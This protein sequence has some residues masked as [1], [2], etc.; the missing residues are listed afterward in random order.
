MSDKGTALERYLADLIRIEGAISVHRFMAEVLMHPEHGYYRHRDPLGAAGDFI[1]APE[2]SQMFGELLGLWLADRWEA[3]GRPD[4]VRLVELGPGR[5]TLMA[6]ALRA[7]RVV[8][9]LLDAADVHMVEASTALRKK[10]ADVVN[11]AWHDR[12]ETVPEGPILV[13]ANEF[14]DALPVH[15]F[16]RGEVGWGERRV[17]LDEAGKL[18]FGIG[19]ASP[20]LAL[21]PP[22]LRDA[23][24]G[25]IVEICPSALSVMGEIARRMRAHGGAGLIID[26]GYGEDAA[27][28]SLQAVRKHQRVGVLD[29]PGD[30]DL[31]A[32]VNFASLMRV[33]A[34]HDVEAFGPLG[35]GA[36]LEAHGIR[37][38]AAM[39]AA[40]ATE[41]KR[42][43][44]NAA[45][46]RLTAPDMM[47]ALFK[48]LALVAPQPEGRDG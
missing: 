43:D 23:S 25:S 31:T 18:A 8:P 21:V 33:A 37:L 47:G 29:R 24:P 34:E 38:R 32:H 3:I 39:L 35:Q 36:F 10:Q 14:F 46:R 27:G 9:E 20:A 5:G 16:I 22:S 44:I 17:G 48:V 19:P 41:K 4:P 2:I 26:Y 45:V 12:L 6:D 11:A 1:T 28:D 30:C 42:R 15:Q 40:K 7:M 13:I